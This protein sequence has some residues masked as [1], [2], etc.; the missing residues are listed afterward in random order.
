[1]PN[2]ICTNCNQKKDAGCFYKERGKK[3]G[4]SSW[5]KKCHDSSH[6]VWHKNNKKR[7][8]E[9]PSNLKEK[10]CNKCK[11]TK[12]IGEFSKSFSDKDGFFGECKAC[13]SI[14]NRKAKYGISRDAVGNILNRQNGKCAVC[15][16]ILGPRFVIDHCHRTGLVRGILCYGCNMGLGIFGDNPLLLRKA[17]SYL[18]KEKTDVA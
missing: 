18:L 3:N 5:C 15:G 10:K 13:H 11:I 8:S 14:T 7:L 4:L 16:K 17:I 9:N 6:K 1:M 12:P 2:L